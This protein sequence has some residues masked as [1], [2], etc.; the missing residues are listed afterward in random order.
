M[1]KTEYHIEKMDCPSEQNLIRMKLEGFNEIRH[2]DFDISQRR[3][4]VYHTGKLAEITSSILHLKLGGKMI[5]SEEVESPQFEE[6]NKQRS[7][8]WIVLII[9]LSFFLLE[10]IFGLFSHSMGLVADSLDMLADSFVYGISLIAV[11]GTLV[12]KKRISKLAGLFQIVLALLGITEVI[13]RFI[14]IKAMPEF[15]TM[16]AISAM[17]L[18]ANTTCL[19]ILQKS[20]S[21]EAHIQASMIFTSNDVI[22]NMGVIIAGILVHLFN[23]GIPDLIAGV[24][25]FTLVI[26]GALR[27]LKLSNK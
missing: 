13:R 5:A 1:K 27:I 9:N 22:I 12:L 7:L 8:L 16:I 10:I 23:T 17:A 3:I 24:I 11:G 19:Y 4:F 14:G 25:V 15:L 6:E 2:I 18:A 26:Q 20:K 21:R